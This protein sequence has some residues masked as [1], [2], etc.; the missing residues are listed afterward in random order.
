MEERMINE[1]IKNKDKYLFFIV[2][3]ITPSRFSIF[4]V[5]FRNSGNNN[6]PSSSDNCS[7]P[8]P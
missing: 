3:L 7:L 6:Y 1:S 4:D 2:N 5:N 8:R